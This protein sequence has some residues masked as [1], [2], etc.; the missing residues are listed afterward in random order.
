[1]R[2]RCCVSV[3]YPLAIVSL[4]VRYGLAVMLSRFGV[5][6]GLDL[7]SL[8]RRLRGTNQLLHINVKVSIRRVFSLVFFGRVV[9]CFARS[10]R[11]CPV[12]LFG[13]SFVTLRRVRLRLSLRL[14]FLIGGYDTASALVS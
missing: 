14:R 13:G 11:R 4:C 5:S 1:M 8:P 3:S 12:V 10:F 2:P 9:F 6:C 7:V